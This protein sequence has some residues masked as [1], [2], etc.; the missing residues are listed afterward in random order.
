MR[1]RMNFIFFI[2]HIFVV[3]TYVRFIDVK[4]SGESFSYL[5]LKLISSENWTF[6]AR[7]FS[8]MFPY[9]LPYVMWCLCVA[10][11]VFKALCCVV[12][13]LLLRQQTS[14]ILCWCT[15]FIMNIF[16][17]S[18]DVIHHS[19]STFILHSYRSY[20][21]IYCSLFV[22]CYLI[23]ILCVVALNRFHNPAYIFLSCTIYA[24]EMEVIPSY[25][26]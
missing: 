21:N 26:P 17:L 4:L 14:L 16:I 19:Y 15:L 11:Y 8:S 22:T 12:D 6:S 20:R 10:T 24:R 13:I 7:H 23:S 2:S 5:F 3:A 1:S 9:N 18:Y 25:S